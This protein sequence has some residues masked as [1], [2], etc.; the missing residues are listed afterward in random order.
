MKGKVCAAEFSC[1]NGPR[2]PAIN[3]PANSFPYGLSNSRASGFC[4]VSIVQ[5]KTLQILEQEKCEH[6]LS[7]FKRPNEKQMFLLRCSWPRP[8][9]LQTLTS[10]LKQNVPECFAG[11][12]KKLDGSSVLNVS[13]G[14][15]CLIVQSSSRFQR[16]DAKMNRRAER[17][18]LKISFIRHHII[19]N[20]L[21]REK[22]TG[23]LGQR[24][25]AIAC[26]QRF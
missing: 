8:F 24:L 9:V 3:P 25:T 2:G 5:K 18:G 19:K 15:L 13:D 12:Q 7:S 4:E 10:T 11:A 6:P 21:M 23:S 17:I 26:V 20:D 1:K 16:T 14:S 22:V